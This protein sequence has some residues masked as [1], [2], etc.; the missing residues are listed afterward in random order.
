MPRYY[1]AGLYRRIAADPRIDFTAIFSSSA[2]V[3][4]GDLGYGRPV[5]FD[6]DA[7]S[8][9]ASVFLRKAERTEHVGSFTSLLDLDVVPELGRRRFDVLWLHGYYSATHLMAATAH[10]MRGGQLLVREEQ[11]LLSSRPLW[12][13]ALK[14]ALLAALFA[15]STGLFLGRRNHEWF[16]H[17]GMPEERLFHVPFCVDND[18]FRAEAGRY[19][20]RELELRRE[21][22]IDGDPGPVILSVGRLIP[23]KQPVL[24][25]DAFRRV[26]KDHRCTLLVI[27]SG[28]S[29]PEMR[30]FVKRHEIP[31]VV[32]AGFMNQSAISRAY[33]AADVFTLT[34][35]W[36]E[37]WGLVVNEAMNFGLPVVVS[38]KVGSA[39]DLV[40]H[41]ENGFVFP[42]DRP[43]ELA[44]Y[45]S[46]LVF[47]E[48]ER[49]AFGRRS[50]E[51]VTAWNYD[52]AADGL[53]A[54]VRS[55]VG[56]RRWAAA[57]ADAEA[58]AARAGRSREEAQAR[59][60]AAA[61]RSP[62]TA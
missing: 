18:F 17:H 23:K 27:G 47:G 62:G 43:D 61:G 59:R 29:E 31:D 9:Y 35:G 14:R 45:L 2:G 10:L 5:S 53:V 15:R 51:I 55:V 20:S 49:A 56:P 12:K 58:Q 44:R 57:E 1:Y 48:D 33:A 24:L 22:G 19:A 41:G 26:R 8:G 3:R 21:F 4:P 6:A 40:R 28:P 25:L 38:D 46:L 16:R 52:V 50:T 34:S 54:A 11:T 39:A 13:R 60:H 30:E 7:L 37:T 32:F 42:H 36:D